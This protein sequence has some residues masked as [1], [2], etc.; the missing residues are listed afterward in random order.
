[1]C[2][3]HIISYYPLFTFL[4]AQSFSQQAISHFSCHLENINA[5]LDV[6]LPQYI[7]A[8]HRDSA[9][10]NPPEMQEIPGTQFRSLCREDP[11]EEE[12]ATHS[13]VLAWRTLCIEELSGQQSMGSETV[14]YDWSNW[15]C[16]HAI[17]QKYLLPVP[18]VFYA[19]SVSTFLL[20][21][22][23]KL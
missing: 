6:L 8:L 23:L 1:M 2:W 21:H 18:Y 19:I 14:G 9:V 11:M 12:M 4:F 10:K 15:A 5:F 22:P 13:N 3:K 17:R 16:M 20:M 7:E